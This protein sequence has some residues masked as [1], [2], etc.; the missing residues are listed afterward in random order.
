[1]NFTNEIMQIP[2]DSENVW[3]RIGNSGEISSPALLVYPDRIESNI[4]KM[5]DVAGS[6]DLVRPH[7]KT[8]KM[9]EIIKLQMKHGITRFKCATIAEAEMVAECGVKDILLAYQPVGPNIARLFNL[10]NKFIG[11][12][13]SCIADC[14]EIIKQLSEAAGKNKSVINIYLDINNGMN[15]TGIEPGEAAVNLFR[16]MTGSPNV[17]A[18]GLHVYDGHI[19]EK[20]FLLRQ[21]LCNDAYAP[22]SLLIA[23]LKKFYSLPIAVVAGGTPTFPIHAMRRDVQTSP[24]TLLLWDYGYSSSFS[25]MEFLH[26]AIL[27]VRVISKPGEDLVCIDLGHKAVASEMPH[28]RIKIL[29]MDKYDIISHNEEHMV[30]RTPEAAGL[31]TGDVLYGI[32]YHICPTVDRF[33]QVSVVREG[34]VS[35]QWNVEARRRRITV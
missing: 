9:P 15:R 30:L 1:M 27:L 29:E 24:G 21:K 34:K 35:G 16:F 8:H 13:I 33:D 22:V 20:D 17:Q 11:A 6:P 32:P 5:I 12:K 18:E 25:E 28:P 7:V 19:H 4:K 2:F 26:A 14:E 31:R 23:E 3:Y 10:K